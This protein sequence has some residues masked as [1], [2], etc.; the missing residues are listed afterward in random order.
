MP[1]LK[2]CSDIFNNRIRGKS[3]FKLVQQI[4]FEV[5]KLDLKV[6]YVQLQNEMGDDME[7]IVFKAINNMDAREIEAERERE[8]IANKREHQNRKNKRDHKMD[9]KRANQK[10]RQNERI[11]HLKFINK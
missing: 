8:N 7:K 11:L 9:H 3:Y 2:K 1:I 10:N 4:N 6:W 5:D